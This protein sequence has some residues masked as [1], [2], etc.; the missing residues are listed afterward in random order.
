MDH[1]HIRYQ[2]KSINHHDH[3]SFTWITDELLKMKT[4]QKISR[5][6]IAIE[7]CHA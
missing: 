4:T 6:V 2:R 5:F 1:I 3:F 7:T